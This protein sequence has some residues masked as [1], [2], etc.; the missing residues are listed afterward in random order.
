MLSTVQIKNHK[1]YVNSELI[2]EQQ[3]DTAAEF[4]SQ[5][6]KHFNI[7]YP[8]FHK[9]DNLCKL[10]ILATELLLQQNNILQ[11]YAPDKIGII[12]SNAASSIETDRQH[13]NSISNKSNYF[14]SPAVFVYTLPNIV[15]GEI[16]IKYKITGE[17]TFLISEKFEP[18]VLINYAQTL[19]ISNTD[20]VIVGWVE[21]DKDNFNC[22][23][24]ILEKGN[25]INPDDITQLFIE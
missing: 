4:F 17:N 24:F 11:Q 8:K 13:Q 7:S 20:A 14:P 16:A 25:E 15:I 2:F 3:L 10:G 12:L 6:Y 21:M 23:L 19:F 18:Q 9:M 22:L 5:L 1:V